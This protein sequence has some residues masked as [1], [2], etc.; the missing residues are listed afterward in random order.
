[1]KT[2]LTLVV[3]R[4]GS[5]GSSGMK[6]K[7]QSGI[8]ELIKTERERK[9]NGKMGFT[10]VEFDD[11][12]DV[13][14]DV[15]DVKEAKDYNLKP[16]GST[17]LWDAMASGIET[18]K[19]GIAKLRKRDQPKT[20]MVVVVTDGGENASRLNNQNNIK[21]MIEEL[22]PQGWDFTFM[23]NDPILRKTAESIGTQSHEYSNANTQAIYNAV[24]GKLGRVRN[25]IASGQSVTSKVINLTPNEIRSLK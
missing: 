25:A 2:Q 12:V 19:N 1:M 8:N 14:Q 7:A 10:L 11:R 16:R 17:A 4:S 22:A 5:M 3:D 24:S 21:K 13:V 18:T 15:K 20:V 23:C 9:I 6:E